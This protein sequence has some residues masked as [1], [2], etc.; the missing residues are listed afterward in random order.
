MNC[1]FINCKQWNC[2]PNIFYFGVWSDLQCT[3]CVLIYNTCCCT[4]KLFT[5]NFA[6]KNDRSWQQRLTTTLDNIT[7]HSWHI[8]LTQK[9]HVKSACQQLCQENSWHH[10]WQNWNVNTVN[11]LDILIL[12]SIRK[13]IIF[14]FF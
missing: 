5:T 4:L 7:N 3:A 12:R 1:L 8:L 2:A 10:S 14:N 11:I 13:R 9:I 6:S